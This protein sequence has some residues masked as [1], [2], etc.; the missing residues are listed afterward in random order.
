[1]L[2]RNGDKK[3]TKKECF[4]IASWFTSFWVSVIWL[5][6]PS[7]CPSPSGFPSVEQGSIVNLAWVSSK[8][9][10]TKRPGPG[11]KQMHRSAWNIRRHWS[12]AKS[13]N[14]WFCRMLSSQGIVPA[15]E[16]LLL[17]RGERYRCFWCFE[18]WIIY[19]ITKCNDW[20][21]TPRH[22]PKWSTAP[23]GRDSVAKPKS[24]LSWQNKRFVGV[25]TFPASQIDSVVL[26]AGTKEK[27]SIDQ[28]DQ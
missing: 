23:S 15:I 12:R 2:K 9:L 20:P 24:L 18:V 4:W 21:G 6:H 28:G 7:I 13:F 25:R 1:M 8:G 14:V 17:R 27:P 3:D 11:K 19:Q 22:A 26:L 16:A 10:K 5:P